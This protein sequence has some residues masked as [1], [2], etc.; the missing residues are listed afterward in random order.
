MRLTGKDKKIIELLKDFYIYN[1]YWLACSNIIIYFFFFLKDKCN[2]NGI[3]SCFRY[4]DPSLLS[5]DVQPTYVTVKI[6]G[7][8]LQIVYPN[9]VM[10]DQASAKRSQVTGHLVIVA[11]KV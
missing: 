9:E 1:S 10:S 6:K 2:I 5:C 11:P 8:Y 7:K 4:L 3:F